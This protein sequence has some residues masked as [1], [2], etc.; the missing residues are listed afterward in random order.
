MMQIICKFHEYEI[1]MDEVETNIYECPVC[2]AIC[3]VVMD[4][5]SNPVDGVS[6]TPTWMSRGVRVEDVL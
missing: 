1:L 5:Y 4:R 6:W 3:T 2:E